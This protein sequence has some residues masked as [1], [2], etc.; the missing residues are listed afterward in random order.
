MGDLKK[1]ASGLWAE[2]DKDSF[3][4]W[5]LDWTN[6]VAPG[7]GIAS[8]VWEADPDLTLSS[9]SISGEFT[10]VWVQGGSVGKWYA[11]TNTV[12]STIGRVDQQTIRLL[13]IDEN[14][15]GISGS[16]LFPNIAAAV[17]ELRRDQIRI[18]SQYALSAGDVS[19]AYLAGKLMAAEADAARQLRIFFRP[20]VM[21][22]DDAPQSEID[23][24]ESAGTH[25]AQEAAY[26]YDS[27]FFQ[28]E[29]WGYLVTKEKPIISVQSITFNYPSP[30]TQVWSIPDTWIRLD[31]KYGHIRLIPASQ[32][33]SAPLSAFI[34][35]ALGGGRTVPF[36]IQ[37]RYT[38]GLSN[39]GRDYPDIIDL[40]KKMAILRILQDSFLPQSGSISSD[41]L[42]QSMSMDVQKWHDGIEDK[43]SDLRDAI[44][45]PRVAFL[46]SV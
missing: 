31:K 7:D 8:S 10:T 22:P 45:G 11:L 24:L 36:M 27:A 3:L 13:I 30:A 46:G 9:A 1:D 6:W 20:T 4:D 33:F 23:A 37:I 14:E 12:T 2:Q 26:D 28:G 19:N 43:L 39:P 32:S 38:A 41:G 40:V 18:A 42:S 25:Y 35:Q 5:T 15:S 34:M 17:D 44:H 29:R 21:I 16:A